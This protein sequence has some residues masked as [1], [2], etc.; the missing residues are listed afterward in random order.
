MP[1]PKGDSRPTLA[2]LAKAVAALE[3]RTKPFLDPPARDLESSVID[4]CVRAMDSLPSSDQRRTGFSTP[5]YSGYAF[6]IPTGHER[7]LD[8]LRQRYGLPD[9]RAEVTRLRQELE[10]LRAERD[11]LNNNLQ[12]VRSSLDGSTGWFQR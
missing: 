9:P 5:G 10:E 3:E 7:V 2:S 6:H 12:A 1:D 11:A 4:R 8:Y